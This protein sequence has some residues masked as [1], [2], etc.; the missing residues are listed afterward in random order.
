[1]GQILMENALEAWAAAIRFCD[2]IINGK[3]TLQYQKSFIA[4]LHNAVELFMKQMMLNNNDHGVV[5]RIRDHKTTNAQL[6]ADYDCAKDLNTFINNLSKDE[7]SA[8]YT[9]GF[10][11]LVKT[12]KSILG[13]SLT[14]YGPIEHELNLLQRLRN[15]ETHF[16]IHQGSFLSETDFCLLH[17]FMIRFY[18]ILESWEPKDR[19]GSGFWLLP[20]WGDPDGADSIYGFER[21]V[22][23]GFT[24]RSAVLNSPL[25]QE[26]AEVLS[27]EWLY[28]APN[29]S[30][31]DIAK[32][33]VEINPEYASQFS[34][35]WP[36]VYMMQSLG[37]IIVDEIFAEELGQVHFMMTVSMQ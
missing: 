20:Y 18:G 28:G 10:D 36:L 1:M 23:H 27:G 7:V 22:L 4:S 8:F 16:A 25:A 26:I 19:S 24:Y 33:M 17:N 37:M 13:K 5:V 29:F 31:Y 6:K 3:C 30:S 9:I 2:E 11:G 14:K 12:H 21:K 34:D 35:I 15:D 32:E